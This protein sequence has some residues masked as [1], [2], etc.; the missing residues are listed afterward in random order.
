MQAY[1]VQGAAFL[2]AYW[3]SYYLGVLAC[4]MVNRLLQRPMAMTEETA[5]IGVVYAVNLLYLLIMLLVIN[6]GPGGLAAVMQSPPLM[7]SAVAT[8]AVAIVPCLL[9][10]LVHNL[11]R[12]RRLGR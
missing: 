8:F 7:M 9:F 4:K 12:G 5:G 6:E 3:L 1:L 11:L 2:L 10:I